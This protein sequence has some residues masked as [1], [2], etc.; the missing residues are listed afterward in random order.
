MALEKRGYY[1]GLK[2]MRCILARTFHR[3]IRARQFLLVFITVC[4][5][6]QKILSTLNLC[7]IVA[8]VNIPGQ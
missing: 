7:G 4:N 5:H 8:I 6:G 2:R 3:N 1:C